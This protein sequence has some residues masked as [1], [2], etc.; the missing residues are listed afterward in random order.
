[1]GVSGAPNNGSGFSDMSAD[2]VHEHDAIIDAIQA[3]DKGRAA[4]LIGAHIKKSQKRDFA[5]LEN[6][7]I[8][9]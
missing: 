7:P 2:L 3:R 6:P 1:M 4:S 5:V 9:Q 8:V